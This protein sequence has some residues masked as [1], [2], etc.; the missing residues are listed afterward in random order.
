V[1]DPAE[2]QDSTTPAPNPGDAPSPPRR[3]LRARKPEQ[4]MPYTLDLMRHRDQFRRRGLKPVQNPDNVQP[5]HK[6]DDEDDQYQ[7]EEENQPEIDKDER[8]VSPNRRDGQPPVKKRRVET[9]KD[10]V[11]KI[12]SRHVRRFVS[13]D[14]MFSKSAPKVPKPPKVAPRVIQQ[15]TPERDVC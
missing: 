12:Q 3:A 13:P 6:G 2:Q 7:S 10:K 8:Y 9:L 4:Q 14:S 1:V 11:E 5:S 15:T